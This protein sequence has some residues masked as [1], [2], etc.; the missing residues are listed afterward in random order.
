MNLGSCYSYCASVANCST[1]PDN[2]YSAYDSGQRTDNTECNGTCSSGKY[3]ISDDPS[4]HTSADQCSSCSPGSYLNGTDC[5]VCGAGKY[6]ASSGQAACDGCPAGKYN[7]D[8]STDASLHVSIDDC[9]L[10]RRGFYADSEGMVKCTSCVAGKYMLEFNDG[11]PNSED[12]CTICDAGTYSYQNSSACHDCPTG[13]YLDDDATDASK[14]ASEDNCTLCPSST[15]G[16]IDRCNEHRG[17]S[18]L[19]FREGLYRGCRVL[20]NMRCWHLRAE[21]DIVCRL[22]N[23][24]LRSDGTN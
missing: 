23:R 13:T 3:I 20:F 18:H 22:P 1:C 11:N 10:C 5:V 9:L 19:C 12:D 8:D 17:L 24:I 7:A 6:A 16:P 14:H 2:T 15:Y 4:D 21:L